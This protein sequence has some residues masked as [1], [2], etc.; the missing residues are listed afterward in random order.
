MKKVISYSLWGNSTRYTMGAIQNARLAH[1]YYPGWV[2]RFYCGQDV[3]K[4]IIDALNTITNTEIILMD[5]AND[6]T[7]MFWRF[8]A[9]SDSDIM[10]SR[11]ADAR[12]S[13]R[14]SCA[15]DRWLS[16]NTC[17]H[18]MRDHP[19]HA[20]P[21]MGGMWGCKGGILSNIRDLIGRFTKSNRYEIDQEFLAH[22]IYPIIKNNCTVHDP[23]YE[24]KP[25]PDECGERIPCFHIGQAYDQYGVVLGVEEYGSV[26]YLDYIRTQEGINIF[27]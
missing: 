6:W 27:S 16:S 19:Y 24:K 5:E 11:D 18:I 7:G 1:Y 17:F 26:S 20:R 23:F 22:V 13:Q 8:Y 21:I 3:D 14:E 2:S 10:L 15:V 12:I 4:N 25:F 9:A